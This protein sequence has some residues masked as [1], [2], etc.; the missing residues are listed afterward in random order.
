MNKEGNIEL[1]KASGTQ[2]KWTEGEFAFDNRELM[3]V[4][5]EIGSWYNIS[6]VF[7]SRPLLEERIYFRMN[8]TASVNEVLGVLNDLGV[9]KF[10][11]E[12]EKIIVNKN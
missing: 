7:H 3:A 10:S 1:E 5:Q 12:E 11:L 8:R 2:G 6:M 9:A 4:M